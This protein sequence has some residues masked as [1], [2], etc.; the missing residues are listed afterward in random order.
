MPT[1]HSLLTA[2]NTYHPDSSVP[3]LHGCHNDIRSWQSFLQEHF[4]M[5]RHN[6]VALLDADA[7][8]QNVVDHFGDE[9]LGRAQEVYT[10]LL[11][12]SKFQGVYSSR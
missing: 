10:M 3:P 1:L 8:Y 7:N 11:L 5:E 12:V 2:I 6:S 9:F 4:P